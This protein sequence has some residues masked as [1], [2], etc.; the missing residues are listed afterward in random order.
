MLHHVLANN[1]PEEKRTKQ[2]SRN[3]SRLFLTIGIVLLLSISYVSAVDVTDGTNIP[4]IQTLNVS[5][6]NPYDDTSNL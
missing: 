4:V 2:R 3:F 1:I 6:L 5:S